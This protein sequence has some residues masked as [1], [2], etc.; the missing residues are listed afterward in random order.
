MPFFTILLYT[1]VNHCYISPLWQANVSVSPSL[2]SEG[3]NVSDVFSLELKVEIPPESTVYLQL[4]MDQLGRSFHFLALSVSDAGK[5]TT[6]STTLLFT[7]LLNFVLS[8]YMT[9]HVTETRLVTENCCC[10]FI[11]PWVLSPYFFPKLADFVF[12]I[13]LSFL[14]NIHKLQ[15][16]CYWV[17]SN[18][19]S[20]DQI[21]S[22]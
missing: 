16:N 4:L 19:Q 3:V 7:I 2:L 15:V 9:V 6:S 11:S 5:R 14:Y 21:Q 10:S 1:N 17:L 13:S 8:S 20:W 18:Y 12:A 22:C